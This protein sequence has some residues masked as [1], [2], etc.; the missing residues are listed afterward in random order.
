[1]PL[2]CA[3]DTPSQ[4]AHTF[5]GKPNVIGYE[6]I[7]EPFVA[8]RTCAGVPY[9]LWRRSQTERKHLQPLYDRLTKAIRAIDQRT[10]IWWEPVTGGGADSGE[11]FKS[12]PAGDKEKSVMSFHSYGPNLIDGHTVQRA[13]EL[14]LEQIK[15]LGGGLVVSPPLVSQGL[16][17]TVYADDGVGLRVCTRARADPTSDGALRREHDLVDR[18]AVQYVARPPSLAHS[19]MRWGLRG[20]R[21]RR[22]VTTVGH[23]VES[24]DGQASTSDAQAL[25]APLPILRR[26][27]RRRVPL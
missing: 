10:M 17:L 2:K 9:N 13:V 23:A 11:G 21:T 16:L 19:L 12:V 1:M 15:R 26:R 4:L 25:L 24:Q 14:R 20:I 22:R 18:M 7:N 5:K 6:L 27:Y 3:P 8:S